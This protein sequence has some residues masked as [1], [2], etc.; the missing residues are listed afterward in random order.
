MKETHKNTMSIKN[1]LSS[2]YFMNHL[3]L[4]DI[5]TNNCK[6]GDCREIIGVLVI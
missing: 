4:L 3:S 1:P 5:S 2:L 6:N